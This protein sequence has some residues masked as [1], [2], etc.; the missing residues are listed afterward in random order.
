M[1]ILE[2][3]AAIVILV[4]LLGL[5]GRIDAE[6]DMREFCAHKGQVYDPQTEECKPEVAAPRG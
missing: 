6:S 1:E 5:A 4:L 3:I 2:T